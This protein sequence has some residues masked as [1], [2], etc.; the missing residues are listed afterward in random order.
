[1]MQWKGQECLEQRIFFLNPLI[2]NL[3]RQV[4]CS[5]CLKLFEFMFVLSKVGV[6][7]LDKDWS[8]DTLFELAFKGLGSIP[9]SNLGSG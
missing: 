5:L 2:G 1:M 9:K 6:K 7:G 4:K 8:Q 3:E